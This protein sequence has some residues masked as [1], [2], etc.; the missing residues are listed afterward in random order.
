MKEVPFDSIIGKTLTSINLHG[1][2]SLDFEFDDGSV[3]EMTHQQDCCESVE[4]TEVHGILDD[5]IGEPI[6]VA[7][8]STDD[9]LGPESQHDESYTWTFYKLRTR[10]TD[11]TLRWYGTS[12]GY[13]SESVDFFKI[14]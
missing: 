12:N 7:E 10:K 5:L 1:V 2:G 6:I 11:V 13:Y 9:N 8:C 4:L 14:K 3:Y